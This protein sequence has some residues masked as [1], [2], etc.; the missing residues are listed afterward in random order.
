MTVGEQQPYIIPQ[1]YV[2]YPQVHISITRYA[3]KT[4]YKTGGASK[5]E[6]G[7]CGQPP[8]FLGGRFQ[9]FEHMQAA[10]HD[11]GKT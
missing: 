1:L 7:L 6:G 10:P 11:S 3:R 5:Y 9:S 4:A 8:E 2:E